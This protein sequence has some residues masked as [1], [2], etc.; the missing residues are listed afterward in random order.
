M[1][2]SHQTFMQFRRLRPLSILTLG[3]LLTGITACNTRDNPDDIRRRTA[4]ATESVRRDAKAV[5]EGVKEGMGRQKT[6]N[7]NK[8]SRDELL[9]LPGISEHQADRIVAGRPFDNADDLVN[10]HIISD[11]EY[12]KIR[13]RVIAGH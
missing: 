8:A 4:E 7:I 9:N 5:A 13:D 10:R 11:S 6:V 2:G 1:R 3:L 12:D